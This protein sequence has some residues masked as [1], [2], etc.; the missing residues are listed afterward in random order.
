VT[1]REDVFVVAK[2]VKEEIG[3]VAI[4]V[5]NA[6]IM[7]CHTFLDHTVDEIIQIFNINV[8]GHFWVS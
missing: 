7:P 1:K 6:G 4:L 2:R 5:N 3:D 8:L